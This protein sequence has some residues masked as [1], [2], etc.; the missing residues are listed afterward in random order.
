V[1]PFA[2]MR[3]QTNHTQPLTNKKKKI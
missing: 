3:K 1:L 2:H